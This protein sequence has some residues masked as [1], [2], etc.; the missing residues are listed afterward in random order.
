MMDEEMD[1]WIDEDESSMRTNRIDSIQSNRLIVL[2]KGMEAEKK[3]GIGYLELGGTDVH[4]SGFVGGEDLSESVEE[5]IRSHELHSSLL[6]GCVL[7][8]ERYQRLLTSLLGR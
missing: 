6:D 4:G 3:E 2:M 7:A 8:K 5:V 1:G